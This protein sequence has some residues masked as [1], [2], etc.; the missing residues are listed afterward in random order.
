MCTFSNMPIASPCRYAYDDDTLFVKKKKKRRIITVWM[1]LL[2]IR[3]I[4][5]GAGISI[6]CA[7]PRVMV[8]CRFL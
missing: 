3:F 8:I 6:S 5:A 4:I 2:I 1:V 7:G